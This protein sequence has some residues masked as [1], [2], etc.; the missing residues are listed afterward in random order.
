M[1]LFN[2]AGLIVAIPRF[3]LWDTTRRGTVLMNVAW[4]CFN[5]MILGVCTAVARELR[6]RRA[7]V[8]V[9][10]MTPLAVKLPDGRS[11]AAETVDMS[12]GGAGIRLGEALAGDLPQQVSLAFP[13]PAVNTELPA[14]VVSLEDSV[15]RVRFENLTI[16]EQE[17][18][19][20]ALYSRAD[21]W[22][23]WGESREPDRVMRS[24][25]H[26]FQVSMRGLRDT[27]FSIFKDKDG[28]GDKSTPLSIARSASILF[29]VATFLL[30]T[31][32]KPVRAQTPSP[33]IHTT[34]N[35]AKPANNARPTPQSPTNSARSVPTSS[36]NPA[37][38][39][40]NDN[41]TPLS[42]PASITTHSRS[43]MPALRKSNCTASIAS[44][45]YI[46]PCRKPTFRARPG[47]TLTMPFLP[48]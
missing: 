12:N 2:I 4:C 28:D 23:N 24:L 17:V 8:R 18:L 15:L 1:L 39:A 14:S 13:L 29:L 35:S 34:P 37:N 47:F 16:A 38:P 7:T 9:R 43:L 44:T 41:A 36:P 45:T 3:F 10:V 32:M 26:I 46:S 31:S 22:L 5:I 25:G 40:N 42:C 6:Q 21:S 30:A 20:I 11:I 27:F 48:L 19:T 33:T